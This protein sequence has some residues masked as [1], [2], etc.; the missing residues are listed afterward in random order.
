VAAGVTARLSAADEAQGNKL[1]AL[2]AGARFCAVRD[3]G[4]SPGARYKSFQDCVFKQ[5][6]LTWHHPGLPAAAR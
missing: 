5:G 6:G 1:N 2:Q 4:F 3:L